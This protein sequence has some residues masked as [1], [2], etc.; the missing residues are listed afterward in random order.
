MKNIKKKFFSILVDDDFYI[1]KSI[2]DLSKISE[3]SSWRTALSVLQKS[4]RG[5]TA[6][7]WCNELTELKA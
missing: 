6:M 3:G 5:N 1:R 2:S 7:V 4:N